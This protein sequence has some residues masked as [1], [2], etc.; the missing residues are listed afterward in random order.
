MSSALKNRWRCAWCLILNSAKRTDCVACG[1]DI[2]WRALDDCL[3]DHTAS[4][5]SV[6]IPP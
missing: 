5:V 4:S 1:R 6:T 3:T 2:E